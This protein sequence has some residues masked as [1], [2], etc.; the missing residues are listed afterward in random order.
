MY[1][2]WFV[3][4]FFFCWDH[5][6]H[7]SLLSVCLPYFLGFYFRDMLVRSQR[8]LLSLGCTCGD[9][10]SLN[11]YCDPGSFCVQLTA[12]FS[13]LVGTGADLQRTS[14]LISASV[15]YVACALHACSS[16]ATG[17]APL[18]L[19]KVVP[20]C[21]IFV[22]PEHYSIILWYCFLLDKWLRLG[23]GG[24]DHCLLLALCAPADLTLLEG[25][26]FY[27]MLLSWWSLWF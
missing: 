18:G 14:S 17:R 8:L 4:L 20:C 13:P 10:F 9:E 21:S 15:L 6:T 22:K 23:R 3:C 25:W 16:F 2:D 26:D 27:V 7:L 1:I 5:C 24:I 19:W 11:S 12:I